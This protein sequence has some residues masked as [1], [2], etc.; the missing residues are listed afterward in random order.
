MPY[1]K[2]PDGSY[3][4]IP[5]GTDPVIA[6]R[7]AREQFPDAFVI[8]TE[9]PENI[10]SPNNHYQKI[11][12]GNDSSRSELQYTS[13]P[14]NK[15]DIKGA[16]IQGIADSV[17][18]ISLV[19]VAL[20][21]IMPKK[22][23]AKKPTEMGR[24]WFAWFFAVGVGMA[25]FTY[26][27]EGVTAALLFLFVI[28]ISIGSVIYLI[29]WLYGKYV[30]FASTPEGFQNEKNIP[31][32]Q[33]GEEFKNGNEN[34]AYLCA[35]EEYESEKRDKALWAKSFALS[36]GD[37]NKTKSHYIKERAKSI[38]NP[39]DGQFLNI[40]E[41]SSIKSG[42]SYVEKN[43]EEKDLKKNDSTS[44]KELIEKCMFNIRKH[45]DSEIML[46]ANGRAAKKVGNKIFVFENHMRCLKANLLDKYPVGLITTIKI[47]EL[48]DSAYLKDLAAKKL[49]YK[50]FAELDEKVK[51]KIPSAMF[52]MANLFLDGKYLTSNK[53][54]AL[55][56]LANATT[57][58]HSESEKLWHFLKGHSIKCIH[59]NAVNE[60]Y[61]NE[62]FRCYRKIEVS[63]AK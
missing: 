53:Q 18:Q 44:N 60:P 46:L 45:G 7:K 24:V 47:D 3:I 61:A 41:N 40:V 5:E 15:L 30:K 54:K 11:K 55:E 36:G 62:C 16:A 57:K 31:P 52:D 29:G 56:L 38:L 6:W 23:K 59:C 22:F 9:Q 32:P 58:G 8:K 51:Q 26:K 48:L 63:D 4:E 10:A 33:N 17:F 19:I 20:F 25:F 37:E 49:S 21:L 12:I 39:L 28:T 1:M 34:E 42:N 43:I 13:K 2:L 50:N 35:L 27:K 14:S